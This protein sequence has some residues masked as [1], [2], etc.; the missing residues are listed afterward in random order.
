[1]AARYLGDTFDIHG[2]GADLIFPHHENE[3]AQSE[4]ATGEGFAR[5]WMHNGMVNL[6]GEK[7]SKSTGHVIDL[8][9]AIDRFGGIMVRL[10]YLRAHYRSPLEFSE[11]LMTDA[12]TSLERVAR[13]LERSPRPD[14]VEPDAAVMDRFTTAMDDDFATPEAL[15]ALFDAVRDANRALDDGSR[16]DALVAAAHE[17]VDVLGIRPPQA[18]DDLADVAD[19]VVRLAAEAGVVRDGGAR[20]TVDALVARRGQARSERDF[21]LSDRIRDRLAAVGILLEDGADGTRWHR[22]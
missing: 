6:G 2:G 17:I 9:E 14:G 19:E 18:G 10:F 12:R 13:M 3:I 15:G 20:S 11:A 8:A 7:M 1:M 4:S 16:A 21:A 22:R 5:Y